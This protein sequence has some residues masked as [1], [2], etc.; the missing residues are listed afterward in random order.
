MNGRT[1]TAMIAAQPEPVPAIV[2]GEQAS[3]SHAHDPVSFATE[4]LAQQLPTRSD[5]NRG[6][7]QQDPLE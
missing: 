4:H 3:R 6:D 7:A 1:G 2:T 5:Q